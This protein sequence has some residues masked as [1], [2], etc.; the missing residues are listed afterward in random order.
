MCILLFLLPQIKLCNCFLFSG[1][2]KK[3][4]KVF[5]DEGFAYWNDGA[6]KLQKHELCVREIKGGDASQPKIDVALAKSLTTS[7]EYN[8]LMLSHVV[9]ALQFL[10]RQNLAS[11]GSYTPECAQT[12]HNSNLIQVSAYLVILRYSQLC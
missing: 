6:R 10:A 1:L 3:C 9:E 7:R 4:P 11:R 5:T 12:E 8:Y 2:V